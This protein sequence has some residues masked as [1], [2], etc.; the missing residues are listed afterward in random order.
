[1]NIYLVRHTTPDVE[2]GICYGQSD[3]GV[4]ETFH[5]EFEVLSEKLRHLVNPV[6]YSSPLTRCFKLANAIADRWSLGDIRQDA[7]LMELHFGDWELK[8][9]DDIPRGLIDVWAQ[10]HVMQ[11]PPQ[12]ESFHSLHLRAKSFLNEVSANIQDT[13]P[14][15]VFTHAG[16]IRALVAEALNLP[17]MN[18]FRL[19]I[20]YGSVTQIIVDEKVTRVGF[21]NL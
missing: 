2:A 10:E 14:V 12:G 13:S 18:A 6:L 9:W 11:T 15:V 5:Q 1:M 20:N 7:R 16:V 3:V 4:T 19:Q 8:K 21:V 17:L